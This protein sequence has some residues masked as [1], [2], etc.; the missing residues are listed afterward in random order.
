ML[1]LISGRI[2]IKS[3]AWLWQHLTMHVKERM[4]SISESILALRI[5]ISIVP[6]GDFNLQDEHLIMSRFGKHLGD[7]LE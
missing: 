6:K 1:G 2:W 7:T 5:V 4:F 3:Y